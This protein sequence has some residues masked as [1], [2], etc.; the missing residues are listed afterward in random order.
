[1]MRIYNK[2]W[3]AEGWLS[4][5]LIRF[6]WSKTMLLKFSTHTNYLEILL[7]CKFWFSWSGLCAKSLQSY[8]TFYDPV[9]CSLPGSSVHRVFQA[10]ILDR[11]AI[12]YSRGSSR[13][14]NQTLS[15]KSPSLAGR[16]FT[17]SAKMQIL[18]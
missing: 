6:L 8:L 18:I 3:E 12:S 16:F 14:R 11:V 15:L 4:N 10:R 9:D 2:V 7:K 13:P 5:Y 17:T 1:M